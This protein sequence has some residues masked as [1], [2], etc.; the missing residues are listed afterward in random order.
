[1]LEKFHHLEYDLVL[2]TM[3]GEFNLTIE[4]QKNIEI[5]VDSLESGF[6]NAEIVPT[7]LRKLDC[8]AILQSELKYMTMNLSSKIEHFSKV[9]S[10]KYREVG[11]RLARKP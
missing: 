9:Q 10:F 1:M 7:L 11:V 3:K 8:E 2:A 6:G 4:L 5:L